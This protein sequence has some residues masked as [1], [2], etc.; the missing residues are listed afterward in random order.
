MGIDPVVERIPCR[1]DD[2]YLKIT[3]F[4]INILEAIKNKDIFPSAFKP[5]QGYFLRYDKPLE[6]DYS[7]SRALA[8]II[9][10]LRK[11]MPWIPIIMD[12]KRGD[13]QRSS[14]N[15]SHEGFISWGADAVTVSPYMGY[16]SLM[17]FFSRG[18]TYVLARTSNKGGGDIQNLNITTKDNE[19]PY[20]LYLHITTLALKWSRDF[21]GNV[22][23]VVGATTPK[24]LSDIIQ[25]IISEGK[26]IP[27]FIPGIGAQGGD[28]DSVM[29]TIRE[30]NYPIHLVRINSSSG[31]NY[32]WE[33]E[34]ADDYARAAVEE[35]Y[36][37]NQAILPLIQ[38]L[39]D[40]IANLII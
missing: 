28:L 34:G 5:N 11:E 8:K 30:N 16:D 9:G 17:P 6:G 19:Y 10:H 38:G 14:D 37:L 23:I 29:E 33:K 32:A 21:P 7:G 26:P 25:L 40:P 27:L 3:E 1:G 24:E 4:Y 35:I 2:H 13:I 12:Y 31:I 39:E 15:Y 18:G 36:R 22:G 20:P